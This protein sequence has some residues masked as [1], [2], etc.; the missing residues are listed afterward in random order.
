VCEPQAN[1]KNPFPHHAVVLQGP[2]FSKLA[3]KPVYH[4]QGVGFVSVSFDDSPTFWGKSK[5]RTH[6]N[7]FNFL[8]PRLEFVKLG[9]LKIAPD[10]QIPSTPRSAS[11]PWV[12]TSRA[13]R[14]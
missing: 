13:P 5:N 1:Q 8:P 6:Q 4:G 10:P 2:N 11:G 12:F 3:L 7:F 14:N 9:P